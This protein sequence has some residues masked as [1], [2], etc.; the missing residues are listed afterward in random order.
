LFLF[1]SSHKYFFPHNS[2]TILQATLA[3]VSAYVTS[4]KDAK[5]APPKKLRGKKAKAKDA[6]VS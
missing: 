4:L 6:E 5:P 1:L 3:R 2:D